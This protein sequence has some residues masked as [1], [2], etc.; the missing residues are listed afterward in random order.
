MHVAKSKMPDSEV[1]ILYDAVYSTFWKTQIIGM[2]DKS[3]FVR[4]WE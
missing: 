3:A 2:E 4:G 1:Y